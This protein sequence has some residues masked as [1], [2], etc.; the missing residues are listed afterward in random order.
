MVVETCEMILIVVFGVSLIAALVI[1]DIIRCRA[2]PG[3][4]RPAPKQANTG[5]PPAARK[6]LAPSPWRA[7]RTR[8]N[9]LET[10]RLQGPRDFYLDGP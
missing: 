1:A 4:P 2:I 10:L 3:A 5:A 7:S 6:V 8:G 9:R